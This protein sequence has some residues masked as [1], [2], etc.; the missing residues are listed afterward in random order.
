MIK[1]AHRYQTN[2]NGYMTVSVAGEGKS[3]KLLEVTKGKYTL[4]WQLTTELKGGV[5]ARIM[6]DLSEQKANMTEN[7]IKRLAEKSQSRVQY[8]QV[9]DGVSLDYIIDP[10][11]VKELI[12][13][14]EYIENFSLTFTLN[15]DLTIKEM[16]DGMWGA[17]RRRRSGFLYPG[18]VHVRQ[19]DHRGCQ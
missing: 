6:D 17:V 5:E 18:H 9:M 2:D 7:D 14:D 16:E 12:T 8:A 4:S 3:D 13:L 11:Q 19:P 1:A 15:T 10:Q